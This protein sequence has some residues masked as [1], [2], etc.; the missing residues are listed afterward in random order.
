[1]AEKIKRKRR[2]TKID[3]PENEYTY[4][5]PLKTSKERDRCIKRIEKI[6]RSSQEYRDYIQYLKNYVDMNACAFFS[7]VSNNGAENKKIKIEIH[8]EPFTLRDYTEVVLDKFIME[9]LPINEMLIAD[10]V[11]YIHYQ[12]MVGLI[13]LSRTI[14]DMVHK[15]NKVK[16]P[17][18][19][20][21]GKYDEFLSEYSKY[22][23][24][25]I[26]EKLE[27]KIN[28]TKAINEDSFDSLECQFEYLE[29]EGVDYAQKMDDNNESTKADV[30]ANVA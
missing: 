10:E 27:R 23:N 14:H 13:P 4:T 11:M 28:E 19:M 12:N 5:V 8:H 9:G 2:T 20:V 25:D 30:S 29:T 26:K 17:L 22:I 3:M 7:N 18:Y 24:D 15:T 21:Y 16:I 6:V 1:M